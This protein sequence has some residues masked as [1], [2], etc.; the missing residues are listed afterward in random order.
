[1]DVTGLRPGTAAGPLEITVTTVS[2]P[3]DT[4][5]EAT[6]RHRIVLTDD[7]KPQITNFHATP[8][9]VKAEHT[10]LLS[11]HF[12]SGKLLRGDF[13]L[14]R[15]TD[16]EGDRCDGRAVIEPV[17][18]GDDYTWTETVGLRRDTA[19]GLHWE[20]TTTAHND[21][22]SDTAILPVTVFQGD[23]DAGCL[24]ADGQVRLFGTPQNLEATGSDQIDYQKTVTD[25]ILL[26][27]VR[28]QGKDDKASVRVTPT[29]GEEWVRE[30]VVT[31]AL[32]TAHTQMPVPAD[33]V[34][35]LWPPQYGAIVEPTWFPF[36]HGP[37]ARDAQG[38]A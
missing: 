4:L 9:G 7:E 33:A 3:P 25:G 17:H 19:Y 15:S 12:P 18:D 6:G 24:S 10:P 31:A 23:V 36:G 16:A 26:L 22:V 38:H 28:Y 32:A 11:W 27:T 29:N 1:V 5:V 30:L 8:S 37:L 20:G 14:I 2:G 35:T 13:F 21:Y 34:V